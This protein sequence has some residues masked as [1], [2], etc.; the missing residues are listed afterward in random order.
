MYKISEFFFFF[1]K[2]EIGNAG[3]YEFSEIITFSLLCSSLKA[4]S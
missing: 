3:G 4:H 1:C 2:E